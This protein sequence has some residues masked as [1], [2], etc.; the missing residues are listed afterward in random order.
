MAIIV[1]L[2]VIPYIRR[3]SHWVLNFYVTSIVSVVAVASC[4]TILDCGHRY[5][6]MY[7]WLKLRLPAL[8]T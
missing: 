5:Y 1:L 4:H 6:M 8:E 7:I 2:V 3:L